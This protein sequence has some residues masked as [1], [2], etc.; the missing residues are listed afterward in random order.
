VLRELDAETTAHDWLD[1]PCFPTADKRVLGVGSVE[2]V[3]GRWRR[4]PS[5]TAG[6][7]WH[8]DLE[9]DVLATGRTGPETGPEAVRRVIGHPRHRRLHNSRRRRRYQLGSLGL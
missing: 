4:A 9:R 5:A 8:R 7:P 2:P 3:A 6:P 1:R